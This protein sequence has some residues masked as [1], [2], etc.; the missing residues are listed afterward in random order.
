M[1]NRQPVDQCPIGR[2]G[3]RA[4]LERNQIVRSFCRVDL[5]RSAG[6]PTGQQSLLLDV[7]A[8][9]RV[10]C[11]KVGRQRSV[12]YCVCPGG[13]L[14]AS[15]QAVTSSAPVIGPGRAKKLK[16]TCWAAAR[17]MARNLSVSGPVSLGINRIT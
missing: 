10:R 15:C 2:D 5:S 6:I 14:R 11:T 7:A 9:T 13:R 3:V 1:L 12:V 16:P 17:M 8:T 4:R